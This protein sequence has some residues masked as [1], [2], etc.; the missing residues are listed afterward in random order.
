MIMAGRHSL[1]WRLTALFAAI[2]TAILL[3]LGLIIGKLVDHHFEEL[4]LELLRGKVELLQSA[5]SKV[6]TPD[7]VNSIAK[8]LQDALVGHHGLSVVVRNARGQTVFSSGGAPLPEE[9]FSVSNI[10]SE[11]AFTWTDANRHR[12]VRGVSARAPTMAGL[13]QSAIVGVATDLSGH[14]EF[15]ASFQMALWSSVGI[16]AV[17]TCGLGW[18][19]ARRGLAP[20]KKIRARTADITA[21]RLDQ[22]IEVTQIPA[23]L[24]EVA[25]T[26]NGMLARLEESFRR[27]SEFSS[28]LAHELR[29]PLTNLLTQT[30]VILSKPRGSADYRDILSSNAEEL[31]RLS[32][33]VAD[34]LFL[35]KA[36]NQLLIPHQED[37]VLAEE[38]LELLEFY[39]VLLEEKG[40]RAKIVGQAIIK[41]DRLM[42]RRAF[43]NLLTN[44]IRHTQQGG[45]VSIRIATAEAGDVRVDIVNTGETIAP[46]HLPRIFD[47]F[48]RVDSSRQH[49]NDGSGLGLPISKSIAKAHGGSIWVN[50][51]NGITTFTVSLPNIL[52]A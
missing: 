46:E 36:E 21:S 28:D 50:S 10:E 39:E 31:E 49:S 23:E 24:A 33:T 12:P 5:I 17:L 2:S 32:R 37:V 48:Y 9:F 52:K 16:A 20:L 40:I 15:M 26:I 6:P 51:A 18:L 30:Q 25:E 43:S 7:D 35:A 4:D 47:R 3:L 22:R 27:L 19:A 41:G 38:L 11:S 1:T 45:F 42:L 34:M 44:A 13:E 8:E 29:T 14:E